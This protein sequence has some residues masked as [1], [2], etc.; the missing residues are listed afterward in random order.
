MIGLFADFF[1]SGFAVGMG[2][3]CSATVFGLIVFSLLTAFGH[4]KFKKKVK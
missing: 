3:L 2:I 4:I 1:L